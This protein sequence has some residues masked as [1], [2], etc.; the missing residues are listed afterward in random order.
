MPARANRPAAKPLLGGQ[1][2]IEGVMMRGP[3]T[4][5]IAVR[6]ADG[7]I[8]VSERQTTTKRDS[9]LGWPIIRGCIA[10]VDTLRWGID[11]LLFSAN[12][13]GA[14]DE[15][16][17]KSEMTTAVVLAFGLVVL[18][19]FVA[20]TLAMHFFRNRVHSGVGLNLI[21]G[22]IRL[23]FF[24]IYMFAISRTAD[25]QRVFAYHGAEHKV[26]HCHEAGLDLT[27]E[28]AR[29]FA[30]LHPRCGTAFLLIVFL[31]AII[32]YSFFG[33]PNP[34]LRVV[35]RLALLPVIAGV[36]YEVMRYLARSKSAV[37]RVLVQPGLLLQRLTT[38]EPDDS[39][40]EVAIAAL[41]AVRDA[42]DDV[43]V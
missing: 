12:E 34:L 8:T 36:A 31:I 14:E 43:S 11:A 18:L 30:V 29:R 27:P 39:M 33:W 17:S 26:I 40:L 15:Q 32:V 7:T 41:K 37:A 25:I 35:I 16:L 21:E 5:A 2:V 28:N 10:F 3:V 13:S 24:V 23:A 20:P 1:A 9:I 4:M 42:G 38:N 22:V 19:F 6:R